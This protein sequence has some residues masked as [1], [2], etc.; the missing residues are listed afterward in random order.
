[1][2]NERLMQDRDRLAK[3]LR[4]PFLII[5]NALQPDRAEALYRELNAF[6]NWESETE[7]SFNKGARDKLENHSPRYSFR[8]RSIDL[9]SPQAP[10]MLQSLKNYLLDENTLAW[11][12][13]VS[14]RR[15][16][17]FNGRAVLYGN[18]D[19][20]AEHN[21][22]Y[23]QELDD[24]SVISRSV[25]FNYYL[26]RDWREEWGGRFIW[27]NPYQAILPSFNTLVMFLVGP[28]SRHWVEPITEDAA[29][30]R[31]AITGWFTAVRKKEEVRKKL[32][33]KLG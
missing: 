18:G 4:Q 10:P 23:N 32:N 14:G 31:L 21:D 22:Y 16:D 29:G 1:M 28:E 15:C 3:G 13:E 25:T 27:K 19:Y 33:L 9:Q 2:L 20:I 30:K 8:R 26:T 6:G 24:G 11:I 17:S 7:Q 5:E 12:S